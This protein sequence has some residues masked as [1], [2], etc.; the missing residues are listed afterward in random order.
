MPRNKGRHK[1]RDFSTHDPDRLRELKSGLSLEAS[2]RLQVEKGT[3][4]LYTKEKP[5]VAGC[6]A[7]HDAVLMKFDGRVCKGQCVY[8]VETRAIPPR[9]SGSRER[10]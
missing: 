2:L 3:I 9:R 6:R 1:I 5:S 8:A 10:F 4:C 7:A